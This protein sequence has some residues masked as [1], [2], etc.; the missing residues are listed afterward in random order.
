MAKQAVVVT[1]EN[2]MAPIAGFDMK[3]FTQFNVTPFKLDIPDGWL[4]RTYR[5]TWFDLKH[6]LTL[7]VHKTPDRDVGFNKPATQILKWLCGD[8]DRPLDVYGPAVLFNQVDDGNY[9]D[10]TLNEFVFLLAEQILATVRRR[11]QDTTTQSS[12]TPFFLTT[13]D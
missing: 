11:G 6:N 3:V 7:Y 12:S 8:P 4:G 9:V 5:D 13:T 1:E 10:Y 2:G